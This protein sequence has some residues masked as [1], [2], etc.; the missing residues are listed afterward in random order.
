[1]FADKTMGYFVIVCH[2]L[3]VAFDPLPINGSSK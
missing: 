1:M 2:G 3:P